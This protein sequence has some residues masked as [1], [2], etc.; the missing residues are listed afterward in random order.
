MAVASNCWQQQLT[1]P[2]L[3]Q[4]YKLISKIYVPDVGYLSISD[5]RSWSYWSAG[6]TEEIALAAVEEKKKKAFST[7]L[8]SVWRQKGHKN[9]NF[10]WQIHSQ[11]LNTGCLQQSRWQTISP[12]CCSWECW[13]QGPGE[14]N[15]RM[16][17][18]RPSDLQKKP[19]GFL[20]INHT[21][22][23][24]QTGIMLAYVK[25]YRT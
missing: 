3:L 12:W 1:V 14:N 11:V 8:W 22:A 20:L 13:H 16:S 7:F 10:A 19:T 9:I 25:K 5:S 18:D 6:V 15:G 23:T 2:S 21:A 4:G 17:Q 24:P